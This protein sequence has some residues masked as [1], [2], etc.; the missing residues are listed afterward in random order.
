M[1]LFEGTMLKTLSNWP[2]ASLCILALTTQG[3]LFANT[4][5]ARTH[6]TIVTQRA[7]RQ[8]IQSLLHTAGNKAR[9]EEKR[10][11]FTGTS[12]PLRYHSTTGHRTNSMFSKI[13]GKYQ[14]ASPQKIPT[15]QCGEKMN[16]QIDVGGKKTLVTISSSREVNGQLKADNVSFTDLIEVNGNA[17]CTKC[18]FQGDLLV[19][20]DTHLTSCEFSGDVE[21]LTVKIT[22]QDCKGGDLYVTNPTGRTK[23]ITQ[24]VYLKGAS[25]FSTIQFSSPGGKVY[26]SSD[27][28]VDTIENGKLA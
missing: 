14:S 12:L 3:P 27:S 20:G 4:N 7:L 5:F 17:T 18:I 8:N 11:S 22:L 10:Y 6:V 23:S 19:R 1:I 13:L 26:C 25:H 21:V 28:S 16:G 24:K 9:T 15:G 2:R